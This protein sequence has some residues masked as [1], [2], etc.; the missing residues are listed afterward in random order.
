[1]NVLVVKANNRP[2]GVSTKMYE[3]FMASLEGE[4]HLEVNI[5]DLFQEVMPYLNQ[6]LY[7]AFDKMAKGEALNDAE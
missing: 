7:S 3:T 1:M 6:D 5:Y 2:D 4:N